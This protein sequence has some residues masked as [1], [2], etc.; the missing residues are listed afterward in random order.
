MV[1]DEKQVVKFNMIYVLSLK[2]SCHL[3]FSAPRMTEN[4]ANIGI[5]G[6][7]TLFLVVEIRF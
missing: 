3:G 1:L 4:K 2:G 7:E 6:I 5:T